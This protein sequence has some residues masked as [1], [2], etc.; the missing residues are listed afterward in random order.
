MVNAP[1]FFFITELSLSGQILS[2]AFLAHWQVQTP[3]SFS[4]ADPFNSTGNLDAFKIGSSK[5]TYS[6]AIENES[7]TLAT[8]KTNGKNQEVLYLYAL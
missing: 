5:A 4:E 6:G 3:L 1:L 7:E 2:P 8:N